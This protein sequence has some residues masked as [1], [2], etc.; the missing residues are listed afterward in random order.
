MFNLI[1][2][3]IKFFVL[4]ILGLGIGYLI[5]FFIGFNL[6]FMNLHPIV[7]I[8]L[9]LIVGFTATELDIRILE[10]YFHIKTDFYI[11]KTQTNPFV[12]GM[13]NGFILLLIIDKLQ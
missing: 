3:V 5:A 4:F 7:S 12:V 8:I 10:K 2:I 13:L 9:I 1:K 11:F 6:S